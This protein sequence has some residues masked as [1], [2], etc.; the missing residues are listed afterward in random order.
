MIF[1]VYTT[2]MFRWKNVYKEFSLF[3]LFPFE[4]G[5]E[6]KFCLEFKFSCVTN[7]NELFINNKTVF[8][9]F[10]KTFDKHQTTTPLK[11]EWLYRFFAALTEKEDD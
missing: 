3:S 6:T 5:R 9:S 7:S 8:H 4:L 10:S 11:E 2:S 1:L